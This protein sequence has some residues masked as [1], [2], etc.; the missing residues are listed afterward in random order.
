MVKRYAAP[1]AFLLAV[2]IAVL[3]VHYTVQRHTTARVAK[4]A[5]VAHH[6]VHRHRVAAETT[7]YVIV[8]RGDSFSAIAA[9][10]HVSVAQLERL[11]P[12]ASPTALRVGR[13]IRVK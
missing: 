9:R 12:G 4:V 7:Q 5:H 6:R 3:G 11:N 8:Q 10:T 13:R 2:T 1:T